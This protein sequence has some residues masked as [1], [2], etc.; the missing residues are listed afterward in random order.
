MAN[1]KE[2][3]LKLAIDAAGIA[4]LRRHPLLAGKQP[5]QQH[6]RNTYYDTPNLQLRAL[7]VALRFRQSG[8]TW[9][10]TLKSG[11]PAA[12][13][14]AERAEWEC[15]AQ[16]GV[17]DFRHVTDTALRRFLEVHVDELKPVFSTD[18]TR[19]TWLLDYAGSRIEL[20]LDR[21][22]VRSEGR[23]TPLCEIELE[24]LSGSDGTALF[25]LALALSDATRLH[26]EIASK[27]E[28]GYRLFR[29][30]A[31]RPV[32]AAPSPANAQMPAPHAFAA[33]GW[34]CLRQLQSN[35]A[36]VIEEAAAA[37]EFLHQTRVA[38]RR[39]R[40]A[41]AFFA[42]ALPAI[43][44]ERYA[45][46]WRNLAVALGAARDWEV[47]R[48]E[49]LP[50][51]GALNRASSEDNPLRARIEAQV[52]QMLA[53]AREECRA[54]LGHPGYSQLLIEFSAALYDLQHLPAG[55]PTSPVLPLPE[56]AR[57]QLKKAW[58]NAK[59]RAGKDRP[60]K[61]GMPQ[62]HRLRIAVK[63]LRY[64]IEFVCPLFPQAPTERYREALSRLQETLGKLNDLNT[65]ERLLAEYTNADEFAALCQATA[66]R[67]RHHTRLLRQHWLGLRKTAKPWQGE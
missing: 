2:I 5:Q 1:H 26:P 38:I 34:Q 40:S 12:G 16:P 3:E 60:D 58:K 36:G 57:Q 64:G 54:A 21:G 27:A 32:S 28:R 9:L 33:L 24:L 25:A 7:G 17:F 59:K 30:E 66:E 51:L 49:T 44:R 35:E 22:E 52:E 61:L 14:F 41:I 39:L 19:E 31:R 15:V 65:A 29:R 67:R 50:T 63:K 48:D 6:L 47:M 4:L 62:L 11:N 56:L 13:G 18:F 23:E 43:Y 20:A 37:P 55:N 45:P 10:L 8:D 46:A 53:A 42:P